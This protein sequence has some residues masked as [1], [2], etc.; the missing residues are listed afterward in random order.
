MK[1][2]GIWRS[3]WTWIFLGLLVVVLIPL[4][5]LL[6]GLW[7]KGGDTW[8]HL[9]DTVLSTYLLNTG[10][11]LLG[12]GS[13]SLLLGVSTAWFVARK[14]FPGREWMSWAL[15][16]PLSIPS[17]IMAFAYVG[18]F[19]FAGPIQRGIKWLFPDAA[20]FDVMQFPV[21]V[22]LLA[23]ALY[24]YVY[25]LA[26]AAFARQS[27]NRLEAARMMGIGPWE[28]FWRISLPL[29]R[30]AI[31]G[32][33]SLVL[34]EVLNDYGA[35]KYFGIGT[36]TTGIFRAWFALGDVDAALRLSGW[37]LLIVCGVILLE[38]SQ[39]G[40]AQYVD[41]GGKSRPLSRQKL[42]PIPGLLISLWCLLPILLGFLLPVYQLVDWAI[43][44]PE[45]L[46]DPDFYRLIRNSF[47]L[48]LAAAFLCVGA[49]LVLGFAWRLIRRP[50]A[51]V[52]LR[53]GVIGYAVPGAVIAIGVMVM[54]LDLNSGVNDLLIY[55][56][57]AG[58]GPF[59]SQLFIALILAYLV[60][61]L[62]VAYNGIEAGFE[63]I[64]R[65]LDEASHLMGT[66][67]GGLLRKVHAPLLKWS[68]FSALILVFVDVLKELP[69]TLI[70]RP[71]N[72]DSLATRTFELAADE[73]LARSAW[74]ALIIVLVSLWPIIGLNRLMERKREG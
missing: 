49:A 57:G 65:S 33:V 50:W 51:A 55:L 67:G 63:Q 31:I 16:L 62:A 66:V 44:V 27:A 48:A 64:P 20:A 15:V 56:G 37:L 53:L 32:G 6:G 59:M 71:F 54:S 5:Y 73:Q 36:F 72:F 35:V 28:R 69:L 13:L 19:D 40:H 70:L 68:L 10:G 39:R 7:G 43:S 24:P 3:P 58:W 45:D 61:F 23:L 14:D 30:P 17:Y 26:R 1:R 4:T 2:P 9:Q 34:M 42:S 38:R 22:L 52:A 18:L 11:L 41:S 47:F 74:P 46:N 29:A 8:Q 12:T 25:L 21:M 60:R